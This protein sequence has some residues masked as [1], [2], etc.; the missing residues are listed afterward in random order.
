[1]Y[2]LSKS[3][4]GDGTRDLAGC[5]ARFAVETWLGVEVEQE[6]GCSQQHG[7]VAGWAGQVDGGSGEPDGFFGLFLV[8]EGLRDAAEGSDLVFDPAGLAGLS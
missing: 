1:M 3:A 8:G 5:L 2:P 4:V 7:R 6:A